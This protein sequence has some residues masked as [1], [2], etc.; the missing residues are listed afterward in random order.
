LTMVMPLVQGPTLA[1]R[2]VSIRIWLPHVGGWAA[3]AG[4]AWIVT[5]SSTAVATTAASRVFVVKE[6]PY[7]SKVPAP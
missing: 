4:L 6:L 5:P 7:S 1:V 2:V 3:A